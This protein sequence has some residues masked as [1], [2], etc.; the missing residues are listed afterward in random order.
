MNI[1]P[2]RGKNDPAAPR[3]A[4]KLI[5]A[6]TTI[7]VGHRQMENAWRLRWNAQSCQGSA[8]LREKKCVILEASLHG[9]QP[10]V[11]S[12]GLAVVNLMVFR[13]VLV[14]SSSSVAQHTIMTACPLQLCTVEATYRSAIARSTVPPLYHRMQHDYV[15]RSHEDVQAHSRS[16]CGKTWQ[17]HDREPKCSE[18]LGKCC[19]RRPDEGR[20]CRSAT[21]SASNHCG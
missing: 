8:R 4:D 6:Q 15:Q 10:Q 14:E 17:N 20:D 5:G 11:R 2:V 16:L 19:S 21:R 3:F 1:L 12:R 7:M 13:C 9:N 18:I